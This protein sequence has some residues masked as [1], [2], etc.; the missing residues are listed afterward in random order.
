MCDIYIN[1]DY[2]KGEGT[3]QLKGHDL[4]KLREPRELY[5]NTRKA[6]FRIIFNLERG[7]LVAF[8][9]K[10]GKQDYTDS[11]NFTIGNDKVRGKGID[12][13]ITTIE[14]KSNCPKLR[15][16]LLEIAKT[17]CN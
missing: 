13:N 11:R 9:Y 8:W 6:N 7:K 12:F 4:V 16:L 15:G 5:D 1:G 10:A 17:I 3:Y 2:G 14:L